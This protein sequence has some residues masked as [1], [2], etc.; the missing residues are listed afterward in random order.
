MNFLWTVIF[1]AVSV[2][3]CYAGDT[4]MKANMPAQTVVKQG[5]AKLEIPPARYPQFVS[6]VTWDNECKNYLAAENVDGKAD[7]NNV[8]IGGMSLAPIYLKSKFAPEYSLGPAAEFKEVE[9]L[10]IEKYDIPEEYRESTKIVVSWTMQVI[11]RTPTDQQQDMIEMRLCAWEHPD[12]AESYTFNRKY[13]GGFQV[14]TKLHVE[15]DCTIGGVPKAN[16]MG[17]EF[18]LSLPEGSAVQQHV[19][20]PTVTGS[21]ILKPSDFGGK[22]P[23]EMNLSVYWKNDTP[24]YV[25]TPSNSRQMTVNIVP[26]NAEV[27]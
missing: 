16:F 13:P 15:A 10:R 6:G 20:D 17:T 23:P 4:T 3:V 27:G 7:G 24:L 5:G 21:V 8:A 14:K 25:F 22:F 26:L 2:T 11:G 19:T 9:G 12:G 1:M 18:I